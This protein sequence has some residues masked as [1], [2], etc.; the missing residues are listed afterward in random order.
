MTGSR[1]GWLLHKQQITCYEESWA[2]TTLLVTHLTSACSCSTPAQPSAILE[3][4]YCVSLSH[5][6][7]WHKGKKQ[8]NDKQNRRNIFFT[9]QKLQSKRTWI[10]YFTFHIFLSAG[11]TRTYWDFS[12]TWPLFPILFAQNIACF[13]M[14]IQDVKRLH[15]LLLTSWGPLVKPWAAI[16]HIV[17]ISRHKQ[18]K[19]LQPI[20]LAV[21]DSTAS[22]TFVLQ[23]RYRI[24]KW[25]I[26]S[27]K[28]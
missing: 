6:C 4:E 7:F 27:L 28:S 11:I 18:C 25:F 22:L 12:S 15:H 9:Q 3:P 10:F 23:E 20:T 2:N 8:D 5:I 24:Q 19:S 16:F 26:A 17:L 13:Q 14:L 21:S 1:L